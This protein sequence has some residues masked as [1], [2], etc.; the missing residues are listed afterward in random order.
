MF[1]LCQEVRCHKLGTE[2]CDGDDIVIQDILEPEEVLSY[3]EGSLCLGVAVLH[4]CN[5]G[6]IVLVH[7]VTVD[8]SWWDWA[9]LLF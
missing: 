6:L 7:D 1:G 8:Y 3:V 5:R 2:I 4:H 9:S